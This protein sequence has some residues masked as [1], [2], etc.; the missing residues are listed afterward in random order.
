MVNM[1]KRYEEFEEVVIKEE[2]GI[3]VTCKKDTKLYDE[4]IGDYCCSY[5]CGKTWSDKFYEET[6]Y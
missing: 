6:G 4:S 5:D 3:C 1:K 2:K